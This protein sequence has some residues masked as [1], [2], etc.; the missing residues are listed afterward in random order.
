MNIAVAE[1]RPRARPFDQPLGVVRPARQE[2]VEDALRPRG[3]A[4]MVADFSES[5]IDRRHLRIA[6]RGAL[7]VLARGL[8]VLMEPVKLGAPEIEDR[9]V[10]LLLD[11]PR[12]L[13]DLD[14]EILV[15]G[16]Q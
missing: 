11:L 9:P 3:I 1:P 6:R 14:I 12:D 5:E 4:G 2:P 7:Q 13:R 8:P 16:R 15:S 10:G